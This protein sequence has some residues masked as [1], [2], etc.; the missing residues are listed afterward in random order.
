MSFPSNFR[1]RQANFSSPSILYFIPKKSQ[2]LRV[3]SPEM[4]ETVFAGVPMTFLSP[5]L[6]LFRFYSRNLDF[7]MKR[8]TG[9]RGWF[10]FYFFACLLVLSAGRDPKLMKY[11]TNSSSVYN[12]TLAMIM[13]E[14]A[15]AV[16]ISDMTSLFTWTCTRCRGLTEGFEVVQLIVDV[17]SCLQHTELDRRLVLEAAGFRL[18]WNGRCKGVHSGFYRAYHCTTIRP[19]I[20]NAVK[21]A[22]EVYGDL[23]TIVTGHSM[24]GAIAAFCALDLIVNHNVPN[25]QVMTFGQPR[26][27]NAVF[28]SY[29]SKHLPDTIRVT[30][31]HDIVP[32][33]PP[34]FSIIPRKTY[35]HF[36]REVWLQDTS[37]TSNR[38]ASYIE[39]VCDDSGED[40]NCSR[41]VIGNSIQDH[42]SYYGVEFPT[43]DPA[44]CWIVMDPVIAEYGSIDSKGNV[45]LFR[46]L[47]TPVP[48]MQ[49]LEAK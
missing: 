1:G 29:Y 30:H 48:R 20:L 47:A 25:V 45:V 3:P 43:D 26:I 12:H 24:G 21:T 31:E 22:K 35:H 46:D 38:L 42:L 13:V 33:L 14:Y 7:K 37:S 4:V 6:E 15:S 28:A 5:T 49:S 11:E 18:S 9:T 44:T 2:L 32:H 10:L 23:D 41:S 19:A 34:Y 27:G 17:E 16:Y 36:P 40:P 8:Y 39:T